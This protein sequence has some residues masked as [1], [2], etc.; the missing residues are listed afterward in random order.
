MWQDWWSILAPDGCVLL[1]TDG[2]PGQAAPSTWKKEINDWHKKASK[3]QDLFKAHFLLFWFFSKSLNCGYYIPIFLV[4]NQLFCFSFL[5]LLYPKNLEF[6]LLLRLSKNRHFFGSCCWLDFGS[7]VPSR[8]IMKKLNIKEVLFCFV[9][10]LVRIGQN[11]LARN[12]NKRIWS[13]KRIFWTETEESRA[14]LWARKGFCH[15]DSNKK[16][17]KYHVYMSRGVRE[18]GQGEVII[19]KQMGPRSTFQWYSCPSLCQ[20]DT[21]LLSVT[22]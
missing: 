18:K 10:R 5:F 14:S 15:G 2:S 20:Q 13:I 21:V 17:G 9:L 7:D 8:F 4:W 1:M 6:K 16:R 12:Q 19:A 11:T 3:I 22:S